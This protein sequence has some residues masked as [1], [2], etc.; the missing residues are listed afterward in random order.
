MKPPKPR[1]SK[2]LD[3]VPSAQGVIPLGSPLAYVFAISSNKKI[4]IKT[5][6]QGKGSSSDPCYYADKPLNHHAPRRKPATKDLVSNESIYKKALFAWAM[7][8]GCKLPTLATENDP[9]PPV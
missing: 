1:A 8:Q 9:G 2:L 5:V 3:L 4:R 7:A 6:Q